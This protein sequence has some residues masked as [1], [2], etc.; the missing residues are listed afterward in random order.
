MLILAYGQSKKYKAVQR[1][2]QDG[3]VA[4]SS[5]P[6]TLK[7]ARHVNKKKSAVPTPKVFGGLKQFRT[8][9]VGFNAGVLSTSVVTGGENDFRKVAP[10]AGYGISVR[11]QFGHIFGL[12][13][14]ILS[15]HM[16]GSVPRQ[17]DEAISS[18]RTEL[19]YSAT[20]SI[21]A[22]LGTV[23]YM[24]RKQSMSFFVLGGEGFLGFAP[25]VY[26]KDGTSFSTK[27]LNGA[28]KNKVYIHEFTTFVGAGVKFRINDRFA[29]NT[30]YTENF[31]DDD[32]LDGIHNMSANGR[33]YQKDKFSYGYASLEFSIG[34]SSKP[35]IDWVNPVS[36]IY[37]E[38]EDHS[39]RDEFEILKMRLTGIEHAIIELKGDS[40]EDGVPDYFDKCP[41]TPKGVIVDGAGCP[42]KVDSTLIKRDSVIREILIK[43]STATDTGMPCNKTIIFNYNNAEIMPAYF[44][45]LD[46]IAAELKAN[47][48]KN[49][50][51]SGYSS[52]EGTSD[53]NMRL[54]LQRA[55]A[56]KAYLVKAGVNEKQLAVKAMG[57]TKAV[58]SNASEEGRMLNRR[59]Q[60]Y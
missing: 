30:G 1:S 35:N 14:D 7:K 29:V 24:Q 23:S 18:Y 22:N 25:T 12:Q 21:V 49:V 54:S 28:F 50:V 45:T 31:I 44:K 42:V 10:D 34:K 20:T 47:N 40:D 17:Y 16:S 27:Y 8:W 19:G 43:N 51:L 32:F 13:F 58:A 5:V 15:G 9:S 38:L 33:D 37:N 39:I 59:V 56:V 53:H 41:N 55:L 36:L 2:L 52:S 57:E 11:K 46:A 3:A 26:Y 6:D 60:I 4:A 48:N